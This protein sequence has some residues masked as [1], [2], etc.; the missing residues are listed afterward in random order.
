M[1]GSCCVTLVDHL[2]RAD[3]NLPEAIQFD[4]VFSRVTNRGST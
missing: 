1:V 4:P 3:A 2:T